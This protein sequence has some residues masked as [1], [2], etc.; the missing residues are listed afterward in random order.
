MNMSSSYLKDVSSAIPISRIA[1]YAGL[2]FMI[3]SICTV[4]VVLLPVLLKSISQK[5]EVHGHS[6]DYYGIFWGLS[7]ILFLVFALLLYRHSYLWTSLLT[8]IIKG[9]TSISGRL[10]LRSLVYFALLLPF[11]LVLSLYLPA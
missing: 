6:F 2:L 8:F 3:I 10:P 9:I 11:T 7:A 5:M 4:S 1:L